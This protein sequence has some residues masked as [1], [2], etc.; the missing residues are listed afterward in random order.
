MTVDDR[1]LVDP[2][3]ARR[4]LSSQFPQWSALPVLPVDHDGWDNRS[5]RLGD[6]L[7]LR[8]PTAERYAA[9]VEKEARWLAPLARYL[10]LPIPSSIAVGQPD[11]GYPRPWAV[12]SWLPGR[13]A[14]SDRI[15]DVSQFAVDLAA[16]LR[17]LQ[18]AP[19]MGGPPAGRHNFHRGGSLRIYDGETHA[20]LDRWRHAAGGPDVQAL[21]AIWLEALAADWTGT[22]VWVH[23]D[24]APGNL[25]VHDGRLSAVIDFGCCGVGDPSCDLVIAWTLFD[26]PSRDAFRRT[27]GADR[28]M[29]ARARGWA[30]WK[31]LLQVTGSND[32]D[33]V[34][35]A[36]CV[37]NDI[38]GSHC[39]RT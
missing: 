28:S 14:T 35:S 10:P 23:G 22:S 33:V 11:L 19:T 27:I 2:D 39:A 6:H 20:C 7:K 21:Q 37:I 25:L 16:F 3:L 5:F 12:Q 4:L 31:A 24:I 8:F 29:W 26:G 32:D 1:R 18:A 17:A 36:R 9:Q 34:S 30:L 13:T 38:V 15:G